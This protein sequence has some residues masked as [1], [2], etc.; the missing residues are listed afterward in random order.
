MLIYKYPPQPLSSSE[1][2]S[3]KSPVKGW[4]RHITEFITKASNGRTVGQ[5]DKQP[6]SGTSGC[7]DTQTFRRHTGKLGRDVYNV[8]S[9]TFISQ[10]SFKNLRRKKSGLSKRQSRS[11]GTINSVNTG[12]SEMGQQANPN[13]FI[14]SNKVGGVD[15]QVS[16]V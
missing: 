11:V 1:N 7:T 2:H 3:Y 6:C 5:F 14:G 4:T 12:Y 16:I 13:R 15:N 8:E 9:P 10:S